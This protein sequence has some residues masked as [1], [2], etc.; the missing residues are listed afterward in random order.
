L[1]E[2]GNGC[3]PSGF[4]ILGNWSVRGSHTASK[5]LDGVIQSVAVTAESTEECTTRHKKFVVSKIYWQDIEEISA[6][7]VSV[8]YT[9]CNLI[10]K[11]LLPWRL[12]L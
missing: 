7:G 5:A 3:L 9:L 11:N 8:D 1:A 2:G 4:F 10:K 12:H 6:T